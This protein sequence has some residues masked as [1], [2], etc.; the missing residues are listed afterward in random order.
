MKSLAIASILLST[1]C[2]NVHMV[3]WSEIIFLYFLFV[4]VRYQADCGFIK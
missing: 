2:I 3:N 4:W 1:F